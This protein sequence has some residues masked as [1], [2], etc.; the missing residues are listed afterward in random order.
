MSGTQDV[1]IAA[2]VESMTRVP[3]GIP[4]I[5]PSGRDRHG[6]WTQPIEDRYGVDR[7]QPVHRRGDD[8]E[9][10]RL[11]PRRARR[12]ALEATARPPPPPKRR[13]RRRDRA[14]RGP[15]R[16]YR[17]DEGIRADASLE[18]L[19]AVET[20]APGGVITAGNASQICDGASGVLVVGEGP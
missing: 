3:M 5:L 15:R 19:A 13:V 12:F 1:V 10:I 14:A 9:Q 4:V 18:G 20:I 2:G 17:S 8:G 6:P 16:R 11:R 7:V